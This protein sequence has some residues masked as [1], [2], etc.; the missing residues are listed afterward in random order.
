[1]ITYFGWRSIFLINVPVGIFGSI[2]GYLRLKEV[3]AK[4]T[5]QKFDYAGSILY[6]IALATILFGLAIGNPASTRNIIILASGLVFFIAVI[7]VELR[8]P[9]PTLDLALF[10]I[11]LFAAGNY[12][13]VSLMPS[14][15][16][17]VRSEIAVPATDTG[18]Q[19]LKNRRFADPDGNYHFCAQ[20]DQRQVSGPVRQPDINF[21]G[22]SF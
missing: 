9:Y 17:A 8:Q 22:V 19:R 13:P 21:G 15:S 2:W 4:P 14:H 18:L 3:V 16:A 11:R 10:K 7:F 12:L 1:M 6:C 20:S 5:G